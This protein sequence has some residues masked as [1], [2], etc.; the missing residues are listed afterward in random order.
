MRAWMIAGFA[1][2]FGMT[3]ALGQQQDDKALVTRAL[4][5]HKRVLVSLNRPPSNYAPQKLAALLGGLSKR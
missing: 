1:G 2:V 5:I 4:E 3:I